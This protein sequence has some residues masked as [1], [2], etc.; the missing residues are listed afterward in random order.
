[1]IRF[2]STQGEM[3]GGRTGNTILNEGEAESGVVCRARRWYWSVLRAHRRRRGKGRPLSYLISK[4][5]V[6][7]E[8]N[9]TETTNIN[10]ITLP[11]FMINRVFPLDVMPPS[12]S[13]STP[14]IPLHVFVLYPSNSQC[15]F[16]LATNPLFELSRLLEVV[17]SESPAASD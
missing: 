11:E 16:F 8:G 7:G 9:V 17:T 5:T 6:M 10:I 13:P 1:M 3:T 14:H 12:S 4:P 2:V 15:L